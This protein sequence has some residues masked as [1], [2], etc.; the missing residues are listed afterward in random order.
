[1]RLGAFVVFAVLGLTPAA[2]ADDEASQRAIGYI[3]SAEHGP[4]PAEASAGW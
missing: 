1:M 3:C 2:T 4:A